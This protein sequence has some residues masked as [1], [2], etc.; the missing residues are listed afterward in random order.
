MTADGRRRHRGPPPGSPAAGGDGGPGAVILL[1]VAFG[2]L[3]LTTPTAV[4]GSGGLT[5]RDVA[6][7]VFGLG[8]ACTVTAVARWKGRGAALVWFLYA[9]LLWPP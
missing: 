5:A 4:V 6:L 9:G 1:R 7:F 2:G 8:T 3:A